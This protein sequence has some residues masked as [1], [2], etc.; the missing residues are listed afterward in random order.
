MDEEKQTQQTGTPQQE[1]ATA[2][3]A[4]VSAA[5]PNGEA[6]AASSPASAA[7]E[8]APSTASQKPS[9]ATPASQKKEESKVRRFFR[10]LLRWVV[11]LLVVFGLGFVAALW[12]FYL[13]MRSKAL[14]A[15]ADAQKAAQEVS[16]LKGQ[17]ADAQSKIQSLE[18]Q[19]QQAQQDVTNTQTR[20]ALT[21]ALADAYAARLALKDGDAVG[22][23]L[24]VDAMLKSLDTLAS[25]VPPEH[26]QAVTE[27]Q[28]QVQDIRENLDSPSYADRK[29]R[30]VVQNLLALEDVL[31]PQP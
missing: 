25:L 24:Y 14:Q 26:A 22:A 4:D 15:E 31:F 8:A 7:Q 2:P 16:T 27:M 6:Q 12:A 30:G 11:G 19:L 3:V 21:E 20:L 10:R 17:L 18:T 5:N 29:I 9:E 28:Q 13:P 1:E 23:G